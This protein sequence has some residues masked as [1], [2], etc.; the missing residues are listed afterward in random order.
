MR[1]I[2]QKGL[3]A[4][5]LATGL[6]RPAISNGA[7][8]RQETVREIVRQLSAKVPWSGKKRVGVSPFTS[9]A[10]EKVTVLGKTLA[11]ELISVLSESEKFH[12]VTLDIERLAKVLRGELSDLKDQK[13][14]AEIGRVFG[15]QVVLTGSHYSGW[16]GRT[17]YAELT[18]LERGT[19]LGATVREF[20]PAWWVW[21]LFGLVLGGVRYR[22]RRQKLH[23]R[24]ADAHYAEAMEHYA[25][26]NLE[27]ARAKARDALDQN[28]NHFEASVLIEKIDAAL[29]RPVEPSPEEP[30]EE[31]TPEEEETV[32]DPR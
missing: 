17:V 32:V 18:D 19:V 7:E 22:G 3:V 11:K 5:F 30:A 4:L 23:K 6:I 2:F 12:V 27:E 1:S 14:R 24:Q 21:T 8:V 13:T 28:P 20:S 26:G 10:T 9:L 29:N 25:A 31:E 16:R 15:I